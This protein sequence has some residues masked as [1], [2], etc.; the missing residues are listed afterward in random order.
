MLVSAVSEVTHKIGLH[1]SRT[2]QALKNY[3]QNGPA[4][5]SGSPPAVAAGAAPPALPGEPA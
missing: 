1:N 5:Q 4:W 2:A 3:A